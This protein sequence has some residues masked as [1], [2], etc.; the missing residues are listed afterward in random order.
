MLRLKL[1]IRLR[2][3]ELETCRN[4]VTPLRLSSVSTMM[5]TT[6]K[7]EPTKNGG[8][9]EVNVA[10]GSPKNTQSAENPESYGQIRLSK[11]DVNSNKCCL[12]TTRERKKAPS[13]LN[14]NPFYF[15]VHMGG[16]VAK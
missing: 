2:G 3:P 11:R 13:L 12:N 7:L 10:E 5:Q 4:V 14:L 1:V 15:R 9:R 16:S 6:V 8:S